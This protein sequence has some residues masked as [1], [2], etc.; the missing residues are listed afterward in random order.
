[1]LCKVSNI[2]IFKVVLLVLLEK[3]VRVVYIAKNSHIFKQ[4]VMVRLIY[5]L[6][7]DV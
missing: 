7:V 3:N 4:K 6:R 2:H 1:M 5:T